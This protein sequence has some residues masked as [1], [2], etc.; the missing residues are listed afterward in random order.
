MLADHFD[1]TG[2]AKEFHRFEAAAIHLVGDR[3]HRAGPHPE[4]PETQLAVAHG[5]VDK[6]NF[7]HGT[8]FT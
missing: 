4:R 1:V 7:L 2:K 6:M 3:E 5:G 8:I